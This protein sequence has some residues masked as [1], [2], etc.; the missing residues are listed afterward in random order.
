MFPYNEVN[1]SEFCNTYWK[2]YNK[3]LV[4]IEEHIFRA[5]HFFDLNKTAVETVPNSNKKISSLKINFLNDSL[6]NKNK[7]RKFKKKHRKSKLSC[8]VNNL[9]L[10]TSNKKG[11]NLSEK[12]NNVIKS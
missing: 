11:T 7:R 9:Q 8:V 6:N 2:K 10:V 12:R 3:A 5:E 1:K 4:D